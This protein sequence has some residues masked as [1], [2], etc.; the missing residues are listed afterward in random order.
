MI[1]RIM[2]IDI[3]ISTEK[4]AKRARRP[5]R[6]E[7]FPIGNKNDGNE[8]KGKKNVYSHEL[9]NNNK[10]KKFQTEK[11]NRNHEIG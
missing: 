6:S 7:K 10:Q 1:H 9:S 11:L 3:Y 4:C 2:Y 5:R 8:L